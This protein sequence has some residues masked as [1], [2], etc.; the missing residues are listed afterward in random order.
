MNS[1]IESLSAIAAGF[2][3]AASRLEKLR[4]I[5]IKDS[6]TGRA[7]QSFDLAFKA[8]LKNPMVRETYP[9]SKAQRIF[10]GVDV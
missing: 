4:I 9:L 10:F 6:D 7:L 1:D 3:R 5:E 2:T 8:A